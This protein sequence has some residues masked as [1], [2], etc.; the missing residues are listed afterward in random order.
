MSV[1][2]VK[3]PDVEA[4]VAED[5]VFDP[6]H[7][8]G[9][10]Y[11][12]YDEDGRIVQFGEG[13]GI[14]VIQMI[15]LQGERFLAGRG[16]PETH[17]VDTSGEAAVLVERPSLEIPAALTASVSEA[18]TLAGLPAGSVVFSG[19]LS[20][21]HEHPGGDLEIGFTIP[22]TYRLTLEPFPYRAIGVVLEVAP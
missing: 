14:G 19:P 20:G 12:K 5:H 18:V 1:V 22:G 6:S 16:Q 13:M 8:Q 9:T 10:E 7:T 11:V 21:T 2:F 15:R 17:W 4:Q 3:T